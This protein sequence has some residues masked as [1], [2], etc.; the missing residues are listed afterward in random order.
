MPLIPFQKEDLARASLHPGVILSW[1]QGLGKTWAAFLW[2]YLRRA[3]RTIIV[4]PEGLHRQ[5]RQTAAKHFRLALPVIESTSDLIKHGL[6]RPAKSPGDGFGKYYIMSY[7]ALT[8]NGADEFLEST[9]H[10]CAKRV[11]DHNAWRRLH[12]KARLESK[13][14]HNESLHDGIGREED[15][16]RCL[17]APSIATMLATYAAQGAGA[18]CMALDEGTRLQGDD[19]IVSTQIR[20]LSPPNRL[21]L[22]ATPIKNHLDSI[23]WLAQWACG[24]TAEPNARFPY[25]G[26]T[27]DRQQFARYHLETDRF[28]TREEERRATD[29]EWKGYMRKRTSRICNVHRF[30]KTFASIVIRRRK[31]DCGTDI[32][33]RTFHTIDVPFGAL[34]KEA[35]HQHLTHRPNVTKA[36]KPIRNAR[37]AI[38]MQ[39]NILRQ[40]ALCPHAESLGDSVHQYP[41][42]NLRS[43]S[44]WTPKLAG[45]LEVV[46]ERLSLGEQVVIGS[47][48]TAFSNTIQHF[49]MEAGIKS[50]LLDGGTT[51]KKRG[52]MV[53][54]FKRRQAS[55]AVLGIK[56]M[57]EGH[58]LECCPNLILPGASWA[59]D[60]NDQLIHRVWRINSPAPVRIYIMKVVASI[61]QRVI[62]LYE[63]K[64]DS[65]Q[66]SLDGQ[67]YED[68]VTEIDPET[69]LAEAYR[70]FSAL[71]ETI[72]ERVLEKQWP[73]LKLRLFNAQKTFEDRTP[74]T[75]FGLAN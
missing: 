58:S 69:L 16:I 60:E 68:T 18:D 49:L 19:S 14:F 30:W 62:G 75:P 50:L 27:E 32:P 29:P 65:A 17:Y 23:F 43:H 12:G 52:K 44:L 63:E 41:L 20:R 26:T 70:D 37:T 56:A 51:P 24:G 2:P 48:F 54:M 39:L 59:F 8:R 31:A 71:E 35:Y 28:I 7:E 33:E 46:V 6:H 74:P 57:A 40:A 47:P 34:Q 73:D 15:G 53:Q 38:G 22:S 45:I 21:V 36:G 64:H 3:S 66:L 72:N 55:V 5:F 25:G 1:E 10:A 9:A 42:A 61:D 11:I 13:D 4:A 67:L